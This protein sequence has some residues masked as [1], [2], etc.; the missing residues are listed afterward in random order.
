MAQKYI[1]AGVG[2]A[3][4]VNKT[5]GNVV[6]TSK[7][8]INSGVSFSVNATD[9]AGGLGNF[10]LGQY[11][12]DARMNITL[13]DALF[14]LNYLALNTGG[15]ISVGGDVQ[16]RETITTT[17]ANTITVTG[18]PKPFLT[19]G[20]I[21]WYSIAGEDNW[22]K[23]TFTGSSATVA[24]LPIGSKVCVE[25]MVEDASSEQFTV[26]A[27]FIPDQCYLLLELPLFKS[28]LDTTTYTNASKIGTVQIEVP[29]Y[30]ISGAMELSL[31]STGSATSSINGMALA[32][33]SSNTSCD[34]SGDYAY[35]KKVIIGA[36][37]FSNVKAIVVEDSD[38]DLAVAGTQTLVLYK[39]YDGNI[40]PSLLAN[41]K[42]TFTSS[43]SGVATV[44]SAGVCTGV[45]AGASTITCVVSGHTDLVATATVTV[46]A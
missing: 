40:L 32:S 2:N 44:S 45:S 18:T 31:S 41:S 25:Y 24:D 5:T 11:F 6:A 3:K 4:V 15:T 7:T 42:V 39:M 10:L 19:L 43:A 34:N 14:D 35:V 21:G 30:Q 8:L 37:E 26:S 13:E 36:D 33:I 12:S 38:V 28:G 46:T 23:I 20:T 16:T 1:L 22:T 17:V 29:S 9:I 27:S